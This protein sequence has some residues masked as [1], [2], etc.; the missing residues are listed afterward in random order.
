MKKQF[1][2][3]KKLTTEEARNPILFKTTFSTSCNL[4]TK[5]NPLLPNL[6]AIIRKHLSILYSNQQ[7]LDIFLHNTRSVTCKRNKDLREILSPSSFPRTT[8]Q[9][10]CYIKECIKKY[11]ICTNFLVVFSD[12]T[13]F[14]TKWKYKIKAIWKCDC[15]NVIHLT[16][17]KCCGKQ[18]VGSTTGFKERF[19]IHK[20]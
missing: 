15:R 8:K 6:K 17:C 7:M 1:S 2:D 11:D 12:F 13:C 4:I 10:E 19:R 3:I 18:Y 5:Y 16:S 9:N 20:K 14:A